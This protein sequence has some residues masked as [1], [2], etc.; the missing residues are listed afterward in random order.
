MFLLSIAF[1]SALA[2]AK[3]LFVIGCGA[4]MAQQK[5]LTSSMSSQLG[6]L[7]FTICVPC[8]LFVQI[9]DSLTLE[10][11][12]QMSVVIVYALINIAFGF[13]SGFICLWVFEKLGSIIE[14]FKDKFKRKSP[15]TPPKKKK[16]AIV[17]T[18]V[19]ELTS[20]KKESGDKPTIEKEEEGIVVNEVQESINNEEEDE[21]GFSN[22]APM[23]EENEPTK[24]HEEIVNTQKQDR[25]AVRRTVL[26]ACTFGNAASMALGLIGS[27]YPPDRHDEMQLAIS[28]V[29]V[30]M[31]ISQSLMYSIGY[32]FLAKSLFYFS[33]FK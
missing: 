32:V 19:Q 23:I 22:F 4:L 31:S 18:L 30:Y 33:E 25:A 29:S 9:G 2:I 28:Y 17:Q 15:I 11:L 6:T 24:Q 27:L 13:I 12:I 3:V 16:K 21:K 5:I 26:V 1:S 20:P 10:T 7:V 8:M 14:F